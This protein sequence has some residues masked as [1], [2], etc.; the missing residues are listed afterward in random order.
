VAALIV[1]RE[2]RGDG[3]EDL[4]QEFVEIPRRHPLEFLPSLNDYIMIAAGVDFYMRPGKILRM[5]VSRQKRSG[6]PDLHG[7][8]VDLV[9]DFGKIQRHKVTLPLTCGFSCRR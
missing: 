9:L 7:A 6:S 5:A 4:V 3:V 2:T 1:E 8:A